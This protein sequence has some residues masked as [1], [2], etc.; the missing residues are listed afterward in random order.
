MSYDTASSTKFDDLSGQARPA[1][2]G[3][4]SQQVAVLLG[5]IGAINSVLDGTWGETKVDPGTQEE[6]K[7]ERVAVRLE[8]IQLALNHATEELQALQEKLQCLF[9][10]I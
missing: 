4:L 2:H 5:T 10:L 6:S 8:T 1:F 3:T 9:S 7:P